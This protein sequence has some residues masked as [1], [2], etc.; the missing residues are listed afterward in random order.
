MLREDDQ[1]LVEVANKVMRKSYFSIIGKQGVTIGN[2]LFLRDNLVLVPG[3]YITI[4]EKTYHEQISLGRSADDFDLTVL[5]HNPITKEKLSFDWSSVREN[6]Q[7]D[8][9][10]DLGI[11]RLVEQKV[12]RP[13]IVKFFP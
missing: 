7:I 1:A 9:H 12:K 2:C 5:L 3:H 11:I 10:K 13:D 6:Y 4:W 8:H